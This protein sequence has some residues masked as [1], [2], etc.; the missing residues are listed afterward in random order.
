[1]THLY[2]SCDALRKPLT[3]GKAAEDETNDGGD[4]R[5]APGG[6]SA[7]TSS[8]EADAH[9][10]GARPRL[11]ASLRRAPVWRC[12]GLPIYLLVRAECWL[13]APRGSPDGHRRA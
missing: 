9:A 7:A 6:S 5:G 11:R 1:V 10:P 8:G 4:A 13:C 2:V 12:I 3:A